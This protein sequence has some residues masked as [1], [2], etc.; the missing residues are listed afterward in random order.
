MYR[1]WKSANRRKNGVCLFGGLHGIIAA[2]NG[3]FVSVGRRFGAGNN[4]TVVFRLFGM[5]FTQK[6]C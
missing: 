3:F 1:V 6:V 4:E 5:T 2:A